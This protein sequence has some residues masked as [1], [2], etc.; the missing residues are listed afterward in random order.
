MPLD[1]GAAK[2][3]K[4]Y[5]SFEAPSL[6]QLDYRIESGA[7]NS[8]SKLPILGNPNPSKPPSIPCS[9]LFSILFS[10]IRVISLATKLKLI[11]NASLQGAKV[12]QGF[13]SVAFEPQISTF[14]F[15]GSKI[16]SHAAV[17]VG[18][19]RGTYPC[20][21]FGGAFFIPEPQAQNAKTVQTEFVILMA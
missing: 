9:M 4:V 16:R 17:A 13:M 20:S 7:R 15:Q 3:L 1:P 21:E 19:K 14:R 11:S 5:N 10:S 8:C 6:E 12:Q 18:L 2:E